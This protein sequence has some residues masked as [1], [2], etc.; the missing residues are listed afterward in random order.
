MLSISLRSQNGL[1]ISLD[2]P[3]VVYVLDFENLLRGPPF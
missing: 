1:H 3:K 2:S